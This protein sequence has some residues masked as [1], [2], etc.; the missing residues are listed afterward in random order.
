[1]SLYVVFQKYYW[2]PCVW[3][4]FISQISH[5][6]TIQYM[7]VALRFLQDIREGFPVIH[8]RSIIY[9]AAWQLCRFVRITVQNYVSFHT[10]NQTL[11]H[12]NIFRLLN[13]RF[14]LLFSTQP[15]QAHTCP[16][17]ACNRWRLFCALRTLRLM[18]QLWQTSQHGWKGRLSLHSN[19][20]N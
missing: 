20:K 4:L 9:M 2:Q 12:H 15:G 11:W 1:V 6:R 16:W 13:R 18:W 19:R 8:A 17:P 3:H 7:L 5:Q 14:R 10:N